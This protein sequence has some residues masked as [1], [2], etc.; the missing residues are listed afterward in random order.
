MGL[1]GR[2]LSLWVALAIV[3]GVLIR[4]FAPIVPETLSRFEYAQVSI[5]VAVLI[6]AMLFPMM[7]QVDFTSILEVRRQPKGLVIT[8]A[9]NWLV[10]PFTMLAIAWFFQTVVFAPLIPAERA[11][12]YLAAA[13]RRIASRHES[14]WIP[15]LP[16]AWTPSTPPNCCSLRWLPA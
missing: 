3:A 12:E 5:P 10:K 8:T 7:V 9:V 11:R 13:A 15:I 16:A 1:F 14:H 6:W 4:R 2:F